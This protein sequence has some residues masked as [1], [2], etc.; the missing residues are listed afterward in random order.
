MNIDIF[1]WP[2]ACKITQKIISKNPFE[3]WNANGFD[4]IHT[5]R[6]NHSFKYENL[7]PKLLQS[8]ELELISLSYSNLWPKAKRIWDTFRS[9]FAQKVE[10]L[11]VCWLSLFRALKNIQKMLIE[12][13]SLNDYDVSLK[14][15]S[16]ILA[17]L[18]GKAAHQNGLFYNLPV[19]HKICLKIQFS[20][21]FICVISNFVIWR[22]YKMTSI[23]T[24]LFRLFYNKLSKVYLW[25]VIFPHEFSSKWKKAFVYFW[26]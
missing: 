10:T 5:R 14:H 22:L 20:F 26:T 9:F 12:F 24:I 3:N 21:S 11:N 8:I 17:F 19:L 6:I 2:I 1:S 7:C 4:T 23:S 16:M 13:A 18:G 15:N 25:N